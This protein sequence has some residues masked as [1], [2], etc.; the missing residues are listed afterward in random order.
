M[1]S[2]PLADSACVPGLPSVVTDGGRRAPAA[3]VGG[4]A[5]RGQTLPA[6]TRC[7]D[8]E[9]LFLGD[10]TLSSLVVRRSSGELIGVSRGRFFADF[11]GQLGYGRALYSRCLVEEMQLPETLFLPAA[12][13]VADAAAAV[14]ERPREFRYDDPVVGF[15]DGSLGTVCVADLFAELAHAHAFDG[16]HD[17]LTGL[18]NRRLFLDCLGHARA[19]VSRWGGGFA[20]LFIDI[21]D[22]KTINDGL[23]HDMGNEVLVAVAALLRDVVGA[24]DTVA[25]LGGDEFAV[26]VE[27]V[28]TRADAVAIADAVVAALAQPVCVDQDRVPLSASVGA[29]LSTEGG[30]Q[31]LLRSADLAMYAAKRRGKGG[32]AFYEPAMSAAALTRLELRSELED[33]L[34]RDEFVLAYQPI[35]ELSGEKVVAV[36]ALLRWHRRGRGVVAPLD[37]I[38]LSEETGLILPIGRWVL[39][40]A[41]RQAERW[42]RGRP[43]RTPL[44][45]AVNISPRQLQ[46]PSIV[47]DVARALADSGLDPSALTLEITEGVFVH[48]MDGTLERLAEL[49]RLGICLALD[50][51]GAGFSSLGYLSRMPIDLLKLDRA[52]IA[53]LGK[54]K[55]RGLAS[56]IVQ[57]ARSLGIDTV[58]EGV[59]RADQVRELQA[60]GCALA[61]GYF[62]ARPLDADA[63]TQFA[64]RH[65]PEQPL[66]AIGTQMEQGRDHS[67]AREAHAAQAPTAKDSSRWRP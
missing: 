60:A 7:L 58:A 34:G 39:S 42:A 24:E 10:P 1:V 45:V 65:A 5:R 6:A 49:K 62:F 51:F 13:S 27:G 35:V 12:T 18:A 25:R 31:E 32:Y 56:G 3:S 17:G 52:F 57:L 66:R 38:P 30:V 54:E 61:Q 14:L 28:T 29:V 40:E 33:A 21:D 9:R 11:T 59:E 20:V 48:D 26:L 41:C 2:S 22:F 4:M 50:D 37:F 53:E 8:L 16:L 15:G 44:R 43:G 47:D 63:V 23:G 36:E 64:L 55:E 19:S 46:E 67:G